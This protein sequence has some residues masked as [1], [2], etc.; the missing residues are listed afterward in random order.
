MPWTSPLRNRRCIA[1]SNCLIRSIRAYASRYAPVASCCSGAWSLAIP[2]PS[3]LDST[4]S[5]TI[6]S[7]T[8]ASSSLSGG[9][10][11]VEIVMPRLSDSMEEGTILQWFVAE[12]DAVKEGEPLVEVETDKASVDLRVRARRHA[13]GDQR[14]GRGQRR[15]RCGDRG[16]RRARRERRERRARAAGERPAA[17]AAADR[18]SART[19]AARGRRRAARPPASRAASRPRRWRAGSPPSWA[20][21]WPRWPARARRA[22]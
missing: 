1:V 10:V 7:Q 8:F 9:I 4:A 12:G 6:V 22:A 19:A 21:I 2:S 13:A 15:G 14:R 5:G 17:A 20:S 16:H 11:A 3:R 18:R